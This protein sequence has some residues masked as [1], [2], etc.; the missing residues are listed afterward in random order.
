M[1]FRLVIVEWIDAQLHTEQV[2]LSELE[3]HLTLGV[4][5]T[6][7]WLVRETDEL[8]AVASTWDK[9]DENVDGVWVIPKGWVKSIRNVRTPRKKKEEVPHA[10]V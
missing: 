5:H 6:T 4:R 3:G 2:K 9:A 7:G 10:S 1:T 8:I